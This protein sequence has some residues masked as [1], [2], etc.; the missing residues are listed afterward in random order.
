MKTIYQKLGHWMFFYL[1]GGIFP[2]LF[3]I[4]A[5]WSSIGRM[6]EDKILWVAFAGFIWGII[7]DYLVLKRILSH[8][9][10]LPLWA[11]ALVYL[12]YSILIY[13]FFVGYPLFNIF[14]AIPGGIYMGIRC[15]KHKHDHGKKLKS[16]TYLF[17]SFIMVALC[18]LT[19]TNMLRLPLTI[20]KPLMVVI[21]VLG[22]LLLVYVTYY[23]TSHYF[24]K[25]VNKPEQSIKAS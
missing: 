21:S 10:S 19:I 24:Q 8:L 20:S 5:L 9:Y 18:G 12:F 15:Q 11:M 25:Y 14:L 6:P 2:L 13:G 23:L 7:L 16:G 17:T 1:I 4:M 3:F 22:G